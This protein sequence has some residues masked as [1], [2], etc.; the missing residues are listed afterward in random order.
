MHWA[1]KTVSGQGCKLS[2]RVRDIRKDGGSYGDEEKE[3]GLET[4]TLKK[5][6][7]FRDE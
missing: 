2:R 7:V 4:S 5:E 3:L 6:L 1:V